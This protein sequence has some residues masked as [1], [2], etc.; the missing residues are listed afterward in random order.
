[1]AQKVSSP[2]PDTCLLLTYILAVAAVMTNWNSVLRAIS[3]ASTSL[4]SYASDRN[5]S[6]TTEE[7]QLPEPLVRIRLDEN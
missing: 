7:P 2:Q 3:L 5:T 1:M 6:E 4:T